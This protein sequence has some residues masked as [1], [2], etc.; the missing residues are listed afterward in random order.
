M[1]KSLLLFAFTGGLISA[2]LFS[3]PCTPNTLG[4]I[5]P[6]VECNLISVNNTLMLPCGAPQEYWELM[7]GDTLLFAWEPDPD[8]ISFCQQ[9]FPI[10]ILCLETP[11]DTLCFDPSLVCDTCACIEIYDPVCGCDGNTYTNYCFATIAGITQWTQGPCAGS[12]CQAGFLFSQS[13]NTVAFQNTSTGNGI[14]AQLA[15]SFG[16]GSTSSEA[17]PVHVYTAPGTYAVCLEVWYFDA[18]GAT[19][20]DSWC[21]ELVIS[22][23]CEP[24]ATGVIVE[25]VE[26]G[27]V[28]VQLSDG[29]LIYPCTAPFEFW[30][31]DIGAQVTIQWQ[32][33][34]ECVSFCQQGI[35]AD[36]LCMPA[37][38]TCQALFEYSVFNNYTYHFINQSTGGNISSW[39][40]EFGDGAG[41]SEQNPVHLYQG[42][43]W[44]EVCLTVSGIDS[45]QQPCTSTYCTMI[46]VTDG[47]I[48][49]SMICPP[50]SLCCD[51]PLIEPVCGCDGVTYDNACVAQLWHGV[52]NYEPGPCLTSTGA[53][54]AGNRLQL[55]PNP[56]SGVLRI[57]FETT[58]ALDGAI[59]IWHTSGQIARPWRKATFMAGKNEIEEDLSSLPAGMYFVQIRTPERAYIQKVIKE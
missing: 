33:N 27:C 14:A 42:P 19:C 25:G 58:Y 54:T 48:D 35:Y 11:G 20:F 57:S 26:T 40:W 16:D 12:T 51:A 6:G 37:S 49:S 30:Q 4:V 56:T 18:A 38:S 39:H 59:G 29:N 8:C 2:A 53:L 5:V 9:G 50:G 21:T 28:L 22:G 44:H 24:N 52:L 17:N 1:K 43:G 47:C 34:F 15:W 45:G 32:P 10:N 13:G 36:I 46:Y 31:L 41:S 23:D 7:L 55:S 3:Q